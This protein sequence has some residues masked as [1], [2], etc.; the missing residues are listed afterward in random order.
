M[1]HRILATFLAIALTTSTAEAYL[2]PGTGAF[3]LQMLI[4]GALTAGASVKIF[5]HRIKG[6]CQ[7]LLRH[8]KRP[9][10]S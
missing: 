5:W 6:F 1:S 4:A 10:D 2:D 9:R 3:I 8:Q 7:G